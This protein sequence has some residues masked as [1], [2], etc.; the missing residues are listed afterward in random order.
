MDFDAV[1][2]HSE[3]GPVHED[4]AKLAEAYDLGRSFSDWKRPELLV[5]YPV[6]NCGFQFRGPEHAA[7]HVVMAS[8]REH[9]RWKA[10]HLSAVHTLQNTEQ[11][12]REAVPI[13]QQSQK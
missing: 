12:V 7:R 1:R 13:V 10:E 3:A 8:D 11:L 5:G 2:F 4:E 6:E 9:L